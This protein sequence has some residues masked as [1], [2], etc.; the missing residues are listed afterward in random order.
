MGKLFT[1]VCLDADRLPYYMQSSL[2]WV[3]FFGK[4]PTNLEVYSAPDITEMENETGKTA[5]KAEEVMVV[6]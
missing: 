3:P 5:A 1:T 4:P 2:N 6:A